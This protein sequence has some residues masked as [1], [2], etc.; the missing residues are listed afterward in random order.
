MADV[1]INGT[2]LAAD[3]AALNVIGMTNEERAKLAILYTFGQ[4]L[5][6]V[7]I[8]HLTPYDL[9]Y[10]TNLPLDATAPAMAKLQVG[11]IDDPCLSTGSV[12][13]CE[14][15]TVGEVVDIIGMPFSLVYKSDRVL[16]RK[17][18]FQLNIPLSG[19]VLPSSLKNIELRIFI[20][21]R[22]F[23]HTFPAQPNQ[24]YTFLWDGLDIYGRK[25]EGQQHAEVKIGYV[26]PAYYNMPSRL[27]QSFGFPSGQLIPG[28]IP[29]R[30][31]AIFWQTQIV[32]LGS[33]DVRGLGLGG[34]TINIQ[35]RY[36]RL[37][38]TFYHGDGGRSNKDDSRPLIIETV[39]G[40]GIVGFSG[41]G[42]PATSARLTYPRGVAMG[43]DGSIYIPDLWNH[44]IRKV[45]PS[46]I[47]TTVAGSGFS[48]YG[49]DGGLATEAQFTYPQGVAV[50]SDGS[51]YIADASNSRIR[52]VDSFGI[53][54]T[55]AGNGLG[56]YSGD[57]GP[58]TAARLNF[59]RGM[60]VGPDGSLYIAEI[61]NHCIRKVDPSGTIITVA[62][63]GVGGYRGDGG[64]AIAAQLSSPGAVAVGSD[65]S[66]FI[67]DYG[68]NR[69]RKVDTSG[70]ITTVAGNGMSGS[71]GSSGEGG[72]AT[73]A[74]VD[75]PISV[76]VGRE[77]D[78]YIAE[79]F[80]PRIRKVDPSG[81][82]STI[83]GNSLRGYSGDGGP[84][85]AAQFDFPAGVAVS[86]EGSLY[87]PDLWNSRI[88]RIR[89]PIPY[90]TSEGIFIP[91]EDSGYIYHF[92]FQGRHLRT[93][94]ALTGTMLYQFS[95]N[96]NGLL[97]SIED[98]DGNITAI[99]RDIN[100]EPLG[101]VAP[102]GQRTDLALDTNGYLA[103]ITNPAGETFAA[104][105][106]AT[107][108]LTSFTDPK[109]NSSQMFY[110]PDTGRLT[111]DLNAAG[112][113]WELS[114]T[115]TDN[116]FTV[117]KASALNRITTY[118]IEKLP[119]GDQRRLVTDPAGLNTQTIRKTNG[120]TNIT[121]PDGTLTSVTEGPDP[122][123]GM[124]APIN[125]ALKITTPAG[126]VLTQ[127]MTRAVT[128]SD[129]NNFLSVTTLTNT[130]NL[131]GRVS[132]NAYNAAT[133]TW[134]ETSAGQAGAH[135]G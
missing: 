74:P 57:G 51:F 35:H 44:R 67:A 131:N 104:V 66:I 130:R 129:P 105:Y 75:H 4:T 82:I 78:L 59:P 125:K 73:A 18:Q 50:G 93:L 11:Q 8:K 134:T 124:L 77:G 121:Y 62:G 41:D 36:D 48:G 17:D 52:K 135:N 54:T 69:V 110:D 26:Y 55:V 101:I 68:N 92:N 71:P 127:N 47:I 9:N 128:L 37:S 98:A 107:G 61:S 113:F 96:F 102:D 123:F 38:N 89:Q 32:R 42:G 63:N 64:P 84:A 25:V 115:E 31:D 53:I 40:S 30:T 72:P 112:G 19:S 118:L 94:N 119:I 13:E 16:G 15:Q 24:S 133:K 7:P 99:E 1:D 79:G 60:A 65:G 103:G 2:G 58:A 43:P 23:K 76:A 81:I 45:N 108:L 122:R 20:A 70:I 106:S 29:A 49:G 86:P 28:N 33:F 117:T 120:E 39:A 83:A 3:A 85:K 97:V 114:R 132:T 12:I 10:G 46:G 87:V 111:K 116:S 90:V 14:N 100:G 27:S 22:E 80:Y 6:R 126:L 5:W 88:R 56:G 21:G 109:T 91:S 95:Y 34:W